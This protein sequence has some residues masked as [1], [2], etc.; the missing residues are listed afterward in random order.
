M[1]T[2]RAMSS[3]EGYAHRHL[4]QSD[5]YDEN[6]TVEGQWHGRGAE[7][8]GLRGQVASEDFEQCGQVSTRK[9]ESSSGNA[10]AR[11]ALPAMAWNKARPA[12]STT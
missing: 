6:R 4:Q 12:R 3:G 1:L 7:L 10:T 9:Q 8:L 2:I 11:I 5:Y